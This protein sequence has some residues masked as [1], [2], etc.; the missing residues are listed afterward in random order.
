MRKVIEG[1]RFPLVFILIL[2]A[3][4]IIPAGT[5]T[6]ADPVIKWKC[7]VHWPTS[8]TSYAGSLLDIIERVKQATNGRFI[9]EPYAAG[10]LVPSTEIYNAVSRGMVQMGCSGVA[11]FQNR[12]PLAAIGNGLPYCFRTFSEALY[13]YK[14]LGFEQMLKDACDKDGVFYATDKIYA[15]ELTLKRP[16]QGMADFKGLKLRSTGTNA[17]FLNALGAAATYLPGAEI[18]PALA[19]GVVEGAH[20]GAAQGARDMKFY[21]VNKYHLLPPLAISGGDG[22]LVNKK[23]LNKLPADIREKLLSILNE[24]IFRRS[25]EY[26]ILEKFAL[27]EVQKKLG[28]KVITIPETDQKKMTGVAMTLWDKEAEKSPENKKAIEI[29]KQYLKDLGYL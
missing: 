20:W 2:S 10:S 4:F 8:S 26:E 24:Q 12:L 5:A 28:V 15:H 7:Q 23:D 17:L 27:A 18:Y 25:N 22:W 11:Y 9:I 29:V 14:F 16:I 13:F 6:A 3:L 1:F 21:E 19:T